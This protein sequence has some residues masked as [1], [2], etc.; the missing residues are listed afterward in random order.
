VLVGD[1]LKTGDGTQAWIAMADLVVQT[2]DL[3]TIDAVLTKTVEERGRL[4]Q[5]FLDAR[6]RFELSSAV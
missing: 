3:G 5:V 1:D 6:K 2:R 4:Y